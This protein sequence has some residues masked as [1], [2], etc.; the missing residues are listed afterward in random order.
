MDQKTIFFIIL[1]MGLVTFI[2]RLL[3]VWLLSSRK[4]PAPITA[5][6]SYVPPAVL[7]A[8]TLPSLV[9]QKNELVLRWDNLYLIA[10][11]PTILVAWKTRSF[12][13]TVLTGILLVALMRWFF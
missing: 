13:G 12:F 9:L 2:P 7:A 5:W 8:L 1:G 4:L 6:L 3:P 11:V 10:A